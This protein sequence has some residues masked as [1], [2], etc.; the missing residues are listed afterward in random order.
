[1]SPFAKLMDFVHGQK[2]NTKPTVTARPGDKNVNIFL[3]QVNI[4]SYLLFESSSV[5]KL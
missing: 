1:M 5:I 3:R 2:V 4:I